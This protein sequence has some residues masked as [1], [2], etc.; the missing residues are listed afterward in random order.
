MPMPSSTI[1]TT[2]PGLKVA[3]LL[4]LLDPSDRARLVMERRIEDYE[5]WTQMLGVN[6]FFVAFTDLNTRT[7]KSVRAM[8][9]TD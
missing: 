9:G 8:R 4:G 2:F 7:I 6:L 3:V 1:R 5:E